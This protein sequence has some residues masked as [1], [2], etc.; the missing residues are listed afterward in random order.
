MHAAYRCLGGVLIA[1]LAATVALGQTT[2]PVKPAAIPK[3]AP[4][5]KTIEG[6]AVALDGDTIQFLLTREKV[7]LWGVDAPEMTDVP[8]GLW[9]RGALDAMLLHSKP[10]FGLR[11]IT[12]DIVD[13]DRDRLVAACRPTDTADDLGAAMI[14]Q[15]WAVTYRI[16]TASARPAD[17][18]FGNGD[19][20]RLGLLGSLYDLAER[21]AREG[22]RGLW[23]G[24]GEAK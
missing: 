24:M 7:R 20:N 4:L 17:I 18:M 10:G 16:F 8:Y 21:S 22:R 14:G 13:R 1:L 6:A 2:P 9:S 12:C 3:A 5:P 19:G 15:G 11:S 23:R